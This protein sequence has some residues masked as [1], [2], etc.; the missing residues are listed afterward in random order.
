VI[1]CERK[2]TAAAAICVWYQVG[3]HDELPGQTGLAHLIE[4]MMFQGTTRVRPN[5]HTQYIE[6]L[7]GA[8]NGDTTLESTYFIDEVPP[9]YLRQALCLEADRMAHLTDSLTSE[10]LEIQRRVVINERLQ[11]YGN[12]PLGQ[13]REKLLSIA[14]P[15]GH[16][17]DHM[18]AG[19]LAD[20]EQVSL[21]DARTFTQKYYVPGN[22]VLSVAGD[23]EA[24]RVMSLAAAFFEHIPAG[25]API[26]RPCPPDVRMPYVEPPQA[27]IDLGPPG[28]MSAYRLPSA[29]GV[30]AIAA[31]LAVGILGG[32][33]WGRLVRNLDPAIARNIRFT[34]FPSAHAPSLAMLEATSGRAVTPR[35]TDHAI[36]AELT[37][38]AAEGPSPAELSITRTRRAQLA[39]DRLT[40]V[41]GL[42]IELARGSALYNDPSHYYRTLAL[43]R[44]LTPDQVRD[45]AETYLHHAHRALLI[46]EHDD[47]ADPMG[48]RR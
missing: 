25:R 22:A 26:E 4:H 43:E 8:A 40:A 2:R 14:F 28:V 47:P 37:R 10:R 44:S 42:A 24:E 32:Q 48:G 7:G 36:Q 23:V 15:E 35:R 9:E 38:F 19:H 31:S 34:E 45:A 46:H 17:Y 12:S 20:L 27:R 21:D 41:E 1:I 13:A 39:D 11:R 33:R 29:G 16:P 5:V 30:P 18:P 3:A 6:S